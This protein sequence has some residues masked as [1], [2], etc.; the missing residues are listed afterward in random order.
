[1]ALAKALARKSGKMSLREVSA[2]LA[3]RRSRRWSRCGLKEGR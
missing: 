2:A 3:R 1:V